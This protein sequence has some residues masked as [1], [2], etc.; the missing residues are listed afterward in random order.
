MSSVHALSSLVRMVTSLRGAVVLVLSTLPG[1]NR[2]SRQFS[3]FI[4]SVALKKGFA[5]K[6]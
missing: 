2:N 1:N 4:Q 6:I 5:P 3:F